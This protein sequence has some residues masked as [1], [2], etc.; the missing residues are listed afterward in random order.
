MPS[1]FSNADVLVYPN[2]V[3]DNITVTSSVPI[4]SIVISN[5][6][7]QQVFQGFYNT[8]QADI[9]ISYLPPG[10]YIAKTNG[11]VVRKFVKE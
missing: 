6:V 10:I 1:V 3:K 4:N 2:P 8:T 9:D 5:L 7:G 11:G